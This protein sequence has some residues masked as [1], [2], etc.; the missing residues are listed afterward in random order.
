MPETFKEVK[1]SMFSFVHID[2]DLYKTSMDC[3]DFFYK[4]MISGGLF[5]FDEYGFPGYESAEKKAVD[6]FFVGK[7][8]V[9]LAL[10]SGQCLVI[11][12]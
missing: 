2:V 3:L 4:R 9:P 12:R 11:K 5:V 10:T 8:E 7:P 6:E 1:D